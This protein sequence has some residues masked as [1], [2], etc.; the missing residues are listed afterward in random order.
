MDCRSV[1]SIVVRYITL[2][3]IASRYMH[4]GCCSAFVNGLLTNQISF[5][6]LSNQQIC[7]F[8]KNAY[9]LRFFGICDGD[10]FTFRQRPIPSGSPTGVHSRPTFLFSNPRKQLRYAPPNSHKT[11]LIYSLRATVLLPETYKLRQTPENLRKALDTITMAWYNG[12]G[13]NEESYMR[14][15]RTGEDVLAVYRRKVPFLVLPQCRKNPE[16]CYLNVEFLFPQ[17]RKEE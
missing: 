3:C 17:I 1:R 12:S 2:R 8:R 14:K 10:R 6:I 4:L 9:L 7:E 16:I 11:T 13:G 5:F 15:R